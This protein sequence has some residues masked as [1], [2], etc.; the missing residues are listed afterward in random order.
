MY[1]RIAIVTGASSGIGKAFIELLARDNG[2]FF[3]PPFDEIW[4]VARREDALN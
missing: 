3:N 2:E 4:A 1:Q